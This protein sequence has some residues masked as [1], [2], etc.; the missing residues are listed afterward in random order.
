MALFQGFVQVLLQVLVAC[1]G[2]GQLGG[3]LGVVIGGQ[4]HEFRTA[5]IEFRKLFRALRAELL[6]DVFALVARLLF[7]L[8]DLLAGHLV[9]RM[10]LVQL[11]AA[12][13]QFGRLLAV[14]SLPI[15]QLDLLPLELVC[16]FIELAAL[17]GQFVLL[18][19]EFVAEL[20]QLRLVLAELFPLRRE[21]RALLVQGCRCF[22]LLAGSLLECF[23]ARVEL[24]GLLRGV[25]GSE[26]PRIRPAVAAHVSADRIRTD[27]R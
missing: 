22:A 8:L 16:E 7:A 26:R 10:L 25:P 20:C 18:R 6:G 24:R 17:R 21:R 11:L 15:G 23:P 3:P 27:P 2:F 4:R 14:S 1:R 12:L 9:L 13:I 5:L 19:I